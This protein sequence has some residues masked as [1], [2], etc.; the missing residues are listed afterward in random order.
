MTT[1]NPIQATEPLGKY[2][3]YAQAYQDNQLTD[4]QFDEFI[5]FMIVT[6][7]VEKIMKIDMD[8]IYQKGFKSGYE[9]GH[10]MCQYTDSKRIN[11]VN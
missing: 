8:E 3:R 9:H 7:E 4:D 1:A 6:A 11:L 2:L 10:L 5:Q